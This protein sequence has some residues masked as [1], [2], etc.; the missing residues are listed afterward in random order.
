M[1]NNELL[2]IIK[3]SLNGS[4]ADIRL[5]S[6]KLVRQLRKSEPELAK[7]IEDLLKANSTRSGEFL[8]RDMNDHSSS[9]YSETGLSLL[10]VHEA[11]PTSKPILSPSILQSLEQAIRER[12]ASEEL[13]KADLKPTSS[14][15]F[16]GPPGVGKTMSAGWLANALNLPF[17]TLDLTVVMSSLLGKTG[18]NLRSVI[19]YAKTHPCV[20]F[21]DEFDAIAKKRNDESDIGELKRLVTVM[22][23]EI[24]DWP[25]QGLLIAA[26]NH[27]ELVDPALWRRFD[28]EV[29]FN[30]P[31][32]EQTKA[33][34]IEFLG[35]DIEHFRAWEEIL[36]QLLTGSSY[37]NIKRFIF[38]LRKERILSSNSADN[39]IQP[40]LQEH[41][42]SLSKTS[43]IALAVNLVV[44]GKLAKSH[45]ARITGISR[46]TLRKHLS[47]KGA[48]NE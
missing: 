43:K 48:I 20:L 33:S 40:L 37:S 14:I 36:T 22:L 5:Y 3:L 47:N 21:L 26:T 32:R 29:E 13:L 17:Y 34:V 10:K 24:E 6:A 30:L 45:A 8:R 18:A 4:E 44:N 25:S 19:D 39:V 23:Q 38:K 16:Q 1:K 11:N 41:I 9:P 31:E 46:D 27:A 7:D 42:T 2:N 35:S 15:I 12:Q 28:L